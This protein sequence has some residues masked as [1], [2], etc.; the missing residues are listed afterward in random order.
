MNI[1]PLHIHS[2][3]THKFTAVIA[4][5]FLA[6]VFLWYGFLKYSAYEADAIQG[7][8]ANSPIM[9]WLYLFFSTQGASNL[10]G[11]VEIFTGVLLIISLRIPLAGILGGILATGTFLITTS[12]MITTPIIQENLYFPYLSAM[13]GQFL[14]KDIALLGISIWITGYAIEKYND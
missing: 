11:T 10:I 8:I 7:L 9:N 13:P 4:H 1:E 5:I 3:S 2:S 12:F 6:I 14:M